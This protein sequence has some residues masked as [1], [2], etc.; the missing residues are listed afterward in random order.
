[1]NRGLRL[2]SVAAML[3][4]ALATP[5]LCQTIAVTG[6]QVHVGDG[7]VIDGGTVLMVDGRIVDVGATVTIPAGAQT[8]DATGKIVTPGLFDAYTGLGL[9]EIG[10]EQN[11]VD[12]ASANDRMTAAFRVVDGINPFATNIPVTRVEGIT[13]AVIA[14]QAFGGLIHGQGVFANLGGETATDMVDRDPVAVYASLGEAGASAAGGA[15]GAATLLLREALDDARDYARNREAFEGGRRRSYALSHLDLQAL[16]PVVRGELPL[17]I[18]ANRASDILA[19]L[20]LKREFDLRMVIAGAQEGWM[21]ADELR[22]SGVPV[23]VNAT[24]NL[25]TFESL[26]ATYENAARLHAAGVDVALSTFDTHNVR[27]LRQVAGM[28]VSHGMPHGAALEAV[29]AGAARAYG[30][31]G[32]YGT[33]A[34]GMPADVVIWTGDPFELTTWAEAVYINGRETPKDSR[35]RAL[36]ERYRDIGSPR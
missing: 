34:P 13:R 11:T 16:V 6:G 36:F 15:R 20:R 18:R 1:M 17:V 19:A 3:T 10:L 26:G 21:V 33:L 5:G 24:V 25:P 7:R 23:I 30:L 32:I 12:A 29:T 22:S 27:N 28:A 9:V 31:D 2:L 4:A 14:P 35:Q 8:V